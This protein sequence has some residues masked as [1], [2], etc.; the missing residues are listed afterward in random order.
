[1]KTLILSLSSS[2]LLLG[3]ESNTNKTP[4]VVHQ[5]LIY[6]SLHRQKAFIVNLESTIEFKTNSLKHSDYDQFLLLIDKDSFALKPEYNADKFSD[7]KSIIIKYL[8]PLGLT[9]DRFENPSIS[10]KILKHS[11]IIIK[12]GGIVARDSLYKLESV[13]TLHRTSNIKT[14]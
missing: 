7:K 5:R 14:E 6:D 9:S 2:I 8:S 10:D 11:H 12:K 13:I 1:M 4:T 3:C